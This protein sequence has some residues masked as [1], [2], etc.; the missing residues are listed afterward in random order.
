MDTVSL[1]RG[2]GVDKIKVFFPAP[3][4]PPQQPCALGLGHAGCW[5]PLQDGEEDD[6]DYDD[7]DDDDD[8][9]ESSS[10][11]IDLENYYTKDEINKMF[12]DKLK[13]IDM[14]DFIKMDQLQEEIKN[15]SLGL[16]QE[17]E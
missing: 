10:E 11:E 6:S 15:F 3:P 1:F 2:G 4:A 14:G 13:N 7:E 8:S 5:W 9:D 17:L 16:G 12:E